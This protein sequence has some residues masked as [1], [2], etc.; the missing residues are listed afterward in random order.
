MLAA[1]RSTWSIPD[2][3]LVH[4]SN[5][6]QSFA[7]RRHSDIIATMPSAYRNVPWIEVEAKQKEVAIAK[8]RTEWLG[9]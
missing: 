8:L 3:Q 5:G 4:I 6:N 1:A 9:N 2:W 7:D